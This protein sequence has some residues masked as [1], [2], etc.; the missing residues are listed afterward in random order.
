VQRQVL[1]ILIGIVLSACLTSSGRATLE[2]ADT[3]VARHYG[4]CLESLFERPETVGALNRSWETVVTVRRLSDRL[5]EVQVTLATNGKTTSEFQRVRLMD[6]PLAE[7]MLEQYKHCSECSEQVI[8]DRVEFTRKVAIGESVVLSKLAKELI[9]IRAPVVPSSAIWLH[10][11]RFY[12]WITSG[13]DKVSFEL[14]AP[15]A[16]V[17]DLHPMVKWSRAL[18]NETEDLHFDSE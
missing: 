9:E 15:S 12:V 2:E 6:Q 16:E 10:A 4:E 1:G 11:D 14:S 7:Q 5:P 3:W 17:E 8:C 18:L 13:V